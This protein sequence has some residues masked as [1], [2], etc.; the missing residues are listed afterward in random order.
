LVLGQGGLGKRRGNKKTTSQKLGGVLGRIPVLP[1]DSST[2]KRKEESAQWLRDLE[3]S[4]TNGLM[5]FR[6]L[7]QNLNRVAFQQQTFI[8]HGFGSW[9]V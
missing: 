5:S 6:L 9:E 2:C 1:T 7:E 3:I 4:R 8:F